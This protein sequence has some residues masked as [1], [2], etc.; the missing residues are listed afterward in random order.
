VRGLRPSVLA[1]A[2]A[3]A[4]AV[5]ASGC[6]GDEPAR[7]GGPPALGGGGIEGL[8]GASCQDWVRA[9]SGERLATLRL[10]EEAVSGPRDEGRTLPSGEAYDLFERACNSG[11]GQ[12]L[13][14]YEVYIRAVA[15]DPLR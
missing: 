10:L 6:G 14:L 11:P 2:L 8:Q 12:G 4:C 5:A 13:L 3:A 15:F 1:V 9:S 7:A